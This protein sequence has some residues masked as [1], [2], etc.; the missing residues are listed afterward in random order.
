MSLTVT[1]VWC[2]RIDSS[3]LTDIRIIA[4]SGRNAIRDFTRRDDRQLIERSG[5]IIMIIDLD[6]VEGP[7][8]SSRVRLPRGP[9]SPRCSRPR[10]PT[11][12]KLN[13]HEDGP[14]L[15]M[16]S[17]TL[18]MTGGRS[19]TLADPN[20]GVLQVAKCPLTSP[21]ECLKNTVWLLQRK[22][23]TIRTY[24]TDTEGPPKKVR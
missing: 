2:K 13:V 6:G 8:W 12:A 22:R 24:G 11:L 16:Y 20:S 21:W 3:A 1:V 5:L 17:M 9:D 19:M 10:R 14:A 15:S 18:P 23:I 7:A 4:S